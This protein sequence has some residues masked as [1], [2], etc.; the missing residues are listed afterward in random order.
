MKAMFERFGHCN[1][2]KVT[3]PS[4]LKLISVIS[5]S[6]CK[7]PG[8]AEAAPHVRD[9][10]IFCTVQPSSLTACFQQ[11]K[12]TTSSLYFCSGKGRTRAQPQTYSIQLHPSDQNVAS[13][14]ASCTWSQDSSPRQ[15]E[16]N[17]S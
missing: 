10:D 8:V 3:V 15:V 13:Q 12:I 16:E 14:P 1:K 7:P 5:P 17:E 11:S 9:S 6:H 2:S 4:S